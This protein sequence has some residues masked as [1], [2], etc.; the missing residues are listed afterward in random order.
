M[1]SRRTIVHRLEILLFPL[2]L[3][4]GAYCATCTCLVTHLVVDFVSCLVTR[5]LVRPLIQN[6]V[7]KLL[8]TNHALWP[9][10]HSRACVRASA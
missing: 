9:Q 1:I 3:G 7:A 4:I 6:S 5:G 2:W 8:K 10:T